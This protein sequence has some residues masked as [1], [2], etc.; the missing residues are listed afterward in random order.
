MKD[1]RASIKITKPIMLIDMDGVLCDFDKRKFELEEK[2]FKGQSLFSHL[3]AYKNLEPM[4]QALEA[5]E[6]LQ[7]HFETY[8]LST[9]AWS[10]PDSW[11]EKRIWVDQYLGKSATKKLILSHNKGLIIGHYLIDDR[12]AN[13]VADFK[14]IHIHYGSKRYPDWNSILLMLG[15]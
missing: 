2:G 3:D 7:P 15:L 13:G 5:W 9:P 10:N 14:G 12:I 11:K 1:F 8:I 6:R 4:P